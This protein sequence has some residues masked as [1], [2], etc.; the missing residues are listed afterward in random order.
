MGWGVVLVKFM[1]LHINVL[2]E[3]DP[4]KQAGEAL[5]SNCN[6]VSEVGP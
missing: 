2:N 4:N 1:S 6:F 3:V 5:V